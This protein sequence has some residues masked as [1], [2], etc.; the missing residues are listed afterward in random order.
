M[1]GADIAL[2][3]FSAS[4]GARILA[5]GPQ[6]IRI[7]RD[8]DGASAV[9]CITWSLF[10]LSHISTVIYAVVCIADPHMAVIFAANALFCV[11]IVTMTVCK[12]LR[13]RRG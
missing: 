7:A 6:L 4:N 10:A 5:Y 1:I 9:S 3:V 12:R 13:A 11:A 8:R 2:A